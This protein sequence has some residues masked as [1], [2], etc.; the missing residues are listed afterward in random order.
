VAGANPQEGIFTATGNE[1]GWRLEIGSQQIVLETNY[2]KTRVAAPSP[3]PQITGDTRRYASSA[4]GKSIIV[5]IVKRVC[6]DSMSGMPHP[7]SVTI[8]YDNQELQG[9]GGNPTELLHGAEWVVT[10]ISG[11]RVTGGARGT[12]NFGNDG[13][14]TGRSFCNNY[15]GTYALTGETLTIALEVSTLMACMPEIMTQ[16]KLFTDLL[17]GVRRFE[18][19][20]SGAL[21]LR[22]G[23]GRTMT[24]RILK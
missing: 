15:S 6:S 10:E 1:P 11:Q 21:I 24:A 22:T 9:C 8:L 5:T 13:R 17:E 3:A 2:G 16:E 7:Q 23:D 20:A 12:L 14:V 4:G 18:I 19:D